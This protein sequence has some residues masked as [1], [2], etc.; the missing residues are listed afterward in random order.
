MTIQRVVVWGLIAA[1]ALS[2]GCG[3]GRPER[4]P[5]SGTVRIDGAPLTMGVINFVPANGRRATGDIDEQ[6]RFSVFTYERGDGAPLG[7]HKVEV[8]S[9]EGLS[10]TQ[11][12]WH[13]PQKYASHKTSGIEV[14]ITEATDDLAIDLTWDGG[15]PFIQTDK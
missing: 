9:R 2:L 8:S 15:K 3:D 10:E 4:V 1:S 11:T 13:T 7:T 6:G 12:R 14:E 5:V